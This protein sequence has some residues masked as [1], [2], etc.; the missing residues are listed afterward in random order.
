MFLLYHSEGCDIYGTVFC[1]CHVNDYSV[2]HMQWYAGSPQ[3]RQTVDGYEVTQLTQVQ[4]PRRWRNPTPAI[5]HYK[6]NTPSYRD[7]FAVRGCMNR[8]PKGSHRPNLYS[9]QVL[10]LQGKVLAGQVIESYTVYY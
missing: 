5:N 4:I 3:G 9:R 8:C 7:R 1:G 2:L 6:G 10:G